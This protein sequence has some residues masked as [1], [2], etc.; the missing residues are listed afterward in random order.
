MQAV[1]RT[2]FFSRAWIGIALG[3]FLVN[4]RFLL[5]Q[6]MRLH[7]SDFHPAATTAMATAVF[8]LAVWF[9]TMIGE[10]LGNR[11]SPSNICLG[12]L[13]GSAYLAATGL[14]IGIGQSGCVAWMLTAPL[15]TVGIAIIWHHATS[16]HFTNPAWGFM[17]RYKLLM[18]ALFVNVGLAY[19]STIFGW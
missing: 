6:W 12:V 17:I 16:H 8:L 5:G 4:E 10:A 2:V 3:L 7:A 15:A 11:A 14:M 1:H 13:T 18:T 9:V 19:V